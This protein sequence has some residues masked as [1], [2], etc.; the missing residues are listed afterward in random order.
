MSTSNRNE[1][2]ASKAKLYWAIG[3]IAAIVAAILIIWNSGI[4][5]RNSAVAT[6]GDQ[7]FNASELAYYYKNVEN[8]MLKQAQSYSAYGIDMG[9]DTNLSP[10]QQMYDEEAGTTY[11]DYFLETALSQLQRVTILCSEAEAAGYTLSEEGQQI[12][13]DNL[14]ALYTYS[15]QQNTTETA[16]LHMVYGKFIDKALFTDI[17]T[18]SVLADEYATYKTEEF[19]YPDNELNKYY[20]ENAADLDLYDYRSCYVH[21]EAEE[22]TDAEGNTIEPTEE[23]MAT[24]MD[25]AGEKAN[26]MVADIQGGTAFNTA[27]VEYL[28]ET[29]AESFK[30]PENGHVT[31]AMGNTIPANFKDWLTNGERQKGDVTAIKVD[32]VGYCVVQFL[33]RDKGEHSYQTA[34]YRNLLVLAETTPSEQSDAP[35]LP[36]EEQLKAAKKQADELLAQWK[37]DG[38]KADAFATLAKENSAD[39]N[40]KE[41][42]GLNKDADRGAVS[43]N[44]QKWLFADGRKAG[45]ASIV[46]HTDSSNNVLGYNIIFAEDFGELRWKHQALTT[47]RSA[48]YEEWYNGVMEQYP[49]ELKDAAK[50]VPD[51]S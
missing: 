41:D 36:S 7:S 46:E 28:D 43:A 38:S 17:L 32:N 48:D 51:L 1:A 6:V 21:Y 22:K 50:K 11:A 5:V 37:K 2:G 16:Y 40:T 24:A 15:L 35:A 10:A 33:G 19:T 44:I 25:A 23:E 31:A 8:D 3:I 45:E 27:A 14:D 9:Y 47:L 26:A 49:A 20:S 13:Q 42:G 34:D 29:S 12:V 4:L 30:D 18:K 39:E